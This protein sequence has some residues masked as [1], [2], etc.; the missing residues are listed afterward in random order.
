MIEVKLIKP[1]RGLVDA[2]QLRQVIDA[3]YQET[4][5]GIR[6]DLRKATA[7]WD[8]PVKIDIFRPPTGGFYIVVNSKIF[9][10]VDKGAKPHYITPVAAR[11]L[12]FASDF[13]PKTKPRT[14]SSSSGGKSGEQVLAK[15]VRHPGF[16]GRQFLKTAQDKWQGTMVRRMNQRLEDLTR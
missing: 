6:N 3:V 7:S 16:E 14:L 9:E 10:L 4:A 12:R 8:T 1:K 11:Y 2:K 5:T 15:K 13:K